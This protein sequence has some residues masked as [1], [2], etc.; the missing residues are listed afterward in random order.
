MHLIDWVRGS[1]AVAAATLG[2]LAL[3]TPPARWPRRGEARGGEK[4][5][6][7]RERRGEA[8]GGERRREGTGYQLRVADEER[9]QVRERV[10]LLDAVELAE[11]SAVPPLREHLR[12][13]V[14]RPA[15]TARAFF[16]PTAARRVLCCAPQCGGSGLPAA[17]RHGRAARHGGRGHMAHRCSIRSIA[18]RNSAS[19]AALSMAL[20]PA[21]RRAPRVE[22]RRQ[23]PPAAP[24][25]MPRR[26]A[27]RARWRAVK[28]DQCVHACACVCACV[29]SLRSPLNSN[30]FLFDGARPRPNR[31][32]SKSNTTRCSETRNT[33][34]SQCHTLQRPRLQRPRAR[35]SECSSRVVGCALRIAPAHAGPARRATLP[36]HDGAR[37]CYGVSRLQ[38]GRAG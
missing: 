24:N 12:K 23:P 29:C 2:G 8:R 20:S 21:R 17:R 1:A 32:C 34:A 11:G 14:G 30:A 4:G 15:A 31:N 36:T 10:D 26:R 3:A 38:R 22:A 35:S 37:R 25:A 9:A 27:A 6:G 7:R 19:L 33:N 5:E 13:R 28:L 16:E 18:C